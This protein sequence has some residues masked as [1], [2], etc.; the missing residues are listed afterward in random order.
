[1]TTY[2][3]ITIGPIYKTFSRVRKTRELWAVSMSFSLLA[4]YL[5]AALNDKG[6]GSDRFVLPYIGGQGTSQEGMDGVGLYPDRIIL[7]SQSGDKET[8]KVAIGKAIERLSEEIGKQLDKDGKEIAGLLSKYFKIYFVEKAIDESAKRPE[9]SKPI[10]AISPYLD[11]AELQNRYQ[12]GDEAFEILRE[13]FEKVDQG[14]N[15]ADGRYSFLKEHFGKSKGALDVNKN[16]RV[17]SLIEIATMGLRENPKSQY[18]KLVNKYLWEEDENENELVKELQKTLLSANDDSFKSFHKYVCIINADGDKIGET[19][20]GLEK[21]SEHVFSNG[22]LNWGKKAYDEIVKYGGLP[23][24]IGGDDLLCFAPV[25]NGL[26]NVFDL[27]ANIRSAFDAQ[28]FPGGKAAVSFGV[29]ITYYKYPMAEAIEKA[30]ELLYGAK[31]VGGNATAIRLLKHS[32]SEF[33]TILKHGKPVEEAFNK[34]VRSMKN[35]KAFNSAVAHHLYGLEEAYSIVGHHPVRVWNMFQNHFD[36]AKDEKNAKYPFMENTKDL[37]AETF[38]D[39][40]STEDSKKRA[41]R[42]IY[43]YLRLARFINGQEDAD[44]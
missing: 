6:I 7:K 30:A 37:I 44:K 13:F 39:H 40:G 31:S 41:I 1:M 27:I 9:D 5:I 43:S 25:A 20:K 36:E 42:D 19:L 4:K 12:R 8:V 28:K 18:R 17:P 15:S 26:E 38:K 29:S 16:L 14:A 22:L 33:D 10:L 32:G 23:I 2:I 34:V 11:H 21:G 3:G 24:Y 35:D